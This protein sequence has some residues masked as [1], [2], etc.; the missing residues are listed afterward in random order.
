MDYYL[1][2]L[3]YIG[4]FS[5]LSL[6]LNL[7]AGYTGLLSLCQAAF[8]AIGAYTTAILL[9][10]VHMNFW[11]SMLIA[12]VL[13]AFVGFLIGLPTLRLKGDYLA[14]ATLGFGEI[15]KNV[16]INWDDLTRGPNGINAI[17]SPTIFGYQLKAS[18][19]IPFIIFIGV[20]V[21][22]TY[23]IID[24]I[25]RSRFGRAL[26]AINDDEIAASSM[27]INVTKYKV[28]SFSIGAF[29]AGI[30]GSL[31]AVYYQ[32]VSPNT[33]D[34]MQSIM[35][36]CMVV[37]GGMGN[38]LGVLL[39]TGLIVVASEFQRIFNLSGIIPP[40]A[41]QIIFGLLLIIMMIYRPQGI[42]GRTK[43]DYGYILKKSIKRSE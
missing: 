32:T 7:I 14:I 40:Q 2:I 24:R 30:A 22:L 11:L 3:I 43:I 29:F 19:K 17:P 28:T 21:V 18:A 27:G 25:V 6:S 20:F 42:L 37:L 9:T 36:L 35:I 34:F 1:Y 15:I 41:N 39:G 8:C 12:G 10:A 4:I 13:S 33:F 26:K 5:I 31:F 23:F 38:P 16:I